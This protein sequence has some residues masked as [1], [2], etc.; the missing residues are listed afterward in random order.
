MFLFFLIND[1]LNFF[2]TSYTKS[3]QMYACDFMQAN[4]DVRNT[5]VIVYVQGVRELIFHVTNTYLKVSVENSVFH[6]QKVALRDCWQTKQFIYKLFLITTWL[7]AVTRM[8]RLCSIVVKCAHFIQN[9]CYFLRNLRC[10]FL[11]TTNHLHLRYQN[12][13]FFMR[14][15]LLKWGVTLLFR[16]SLLFE[17][18]NVH[19]VV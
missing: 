16:L 18:R 2:S 15:L 11:L 4:S 9:F 17:V 14:N 7:T 19:S 13:E 6:Q 12:Q 8:F 1:Y 3:R 10:Q 5:P